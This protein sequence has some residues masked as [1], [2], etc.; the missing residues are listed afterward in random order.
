MIHPIVPI[1]PQNIL[2]VWVLESRQRNWGPK[3]KQGYKKTGVV[4]KLAATGYI[5]T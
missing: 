1:V 2:C 4:E 5:Q 3:E